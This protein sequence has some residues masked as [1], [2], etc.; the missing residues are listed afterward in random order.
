MMQRVLL[1]L[2]EAAPLIKILLTLQLQILGRCLGVDF[3]NE[4]RNLQIANY[5]QTLR[6]EQNLTLEQ[7]SHL[8]Q[9]PIVHL[10]SIEEGRFSRFDDFYLRMYLK[11]YTASLDVDLEQLYIYASQQPFDLS[12]NTR[13]EQKAERQMTQTQANI[14]A[15]PKN[16]ENTKPQRKKPAV[17]T[18]NISRLEAKKRIGKFIIG[19]SFVVLLAAIVIF[20]VI[21]IG[22]L[23]DREPAQTE[24][25][26]IENPHEINP[27]PT[28]EIDPETEP[29]PEPETEPEPEPE[30]TIEFVSSEGIHQT[31]NVVTSVEELELRIEFSDR[32][33]VETRFDNVVF[34]EGTFDAGQYIE[35]ILDFDGEGEF[36]LIFG[37]A[38]GVE[39]LI[40]NGEEVGIFTDHPGPQRIVLNVTALE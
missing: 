33:W 9:V 34:A 29:E 20:L 25:L 23:G 38:R 8:S 1:S 39:R 5:L 28:E 24:Q 13:P 15:T 2:N 31:F 18:A 30:T 7:L 22:S 14:S 40:L 6:L 36:Y 19:L 16:I 35:E 26:P 17:K 12:E 11:R 3:S 4:N 37:F 27:Y 10:V 32:C 21:I